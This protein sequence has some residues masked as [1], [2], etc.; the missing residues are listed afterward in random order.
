MK[1]LFSFFS[2]LLFFSCKE[3]PPVIPPVIT[4]TVHYETNCPVTLDSLVVNPDTLLTPPPPLEYPGYRFGGWYRNADFSTPWNFEK[5]TVNSN[6]ILY[7]KWDFIV[8]YKVDFLTDEQ[9]FFAIEIEKDSLIPYQEPPEKQGYVFLGWHADKE[10]IK[11]W[12]FNNTSIQQPMT[13]YASWGVMALTDTVVLGNQVWSEVVKFP[14]GENMFNWDFA[15]EKKAVLCPYPWRIPVE[16]D[17]VILD[18]SLG[19]L[20]IASLSNLELL[21]KYQEIWKAR[22]EGYM[23]PDNTFDYVNHGAFYWSQSSQGEQGVALTMFSQGNIIPAQL[24]PKK[25]YLQVRC[26]KEK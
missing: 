4:Y 22:L 13:L 11:K 24:H 2:L 7:A 18:K 26:I 19:G 16:K 21:E 8:M 23:K 3:E 5:D 25:T 9:L 20:G 1:Y 10:K 17:F 15:M 14:N 6:L 12:N